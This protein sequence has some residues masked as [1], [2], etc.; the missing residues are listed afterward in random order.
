MSKDSQDSV[1]S[2]DYFELSK[3]P[4]FE[5]EEELHRRLPTPRYTKSQLKDF[6]INYV[7]TCRP[8]I[9]ANLS[10]SSNKYPLAILDINL[11]G[12]IKV[13][14]SE[15]APFDVTFHEVPIHTY[16]PHT[17]FSYRSN[18][19]SGCYNYVSNF[20]NPERMAEWYK[21][22]VKKYNM[23]LTIKEHNFDT[24]FP[25]I[26]YEQTN[27]ELKKYYKDLISI[28]RRLIDIKKT[29]SE[30]E[31]EDIKELKDKARISTHMYKQ[32]KE[33]ISSQSY[34]HP[35]HILNKSYSATSSVTKRYD[36][37]DPESSLIVSYVY[38]AQ[39]TDETE[40]NSVEIVHFDLLQLEY[41]EELY[42]YQNK[43]IYSLT[44]LLEFIFPKQSEFILDYK[45][46]DNPFYN[47]TTRKIIPFIE[48]VDK[49]TNVQAN[50]QYQENTPEN[51][52]EKEKYYSFNTENLLSFLNA[53]NL[54]KLYIY[55][56]SCSGY[57]GM[58][59]L[60]M[61]QH[62]DESVHELP[63]NIARGT[64][65]R[66]VKTKKNKRRRGR[67]ITS[68]KRKTHHHKRR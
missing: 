32:L 26:N 44:D 16:L 55:D 29:S 4:I 2:L 64:R 35:T 66:K 15:K 49:L 45:N 51:I 18:T 31:R 9:P 7:S 46:P 36:I 61:I 38:E 19:L 21:K 17:E 10:A 43:C 1:N 50:H 56:N 59:E 22:Y 37:N 52:A 40:E 33:Y 14:I 24:I 65:K 5:E 20:Y 42:K 68:S 53:L 34:V 41:N 8:I 27:K 58:D 60:F 30:E 57:E 62:I 54:K 63:K 67:G 25:T 13:D 47:D 28:R 6:E 3:S 39:E 12:A 48:Y 23:L 11:H